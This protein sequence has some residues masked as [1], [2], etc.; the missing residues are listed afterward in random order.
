MDGFVG[1]LISSTNKHE[2]TKNLP[3]LQEMKVT[4]LHTTLCFQFIIY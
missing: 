2:M 3:Y 4:D 1:E